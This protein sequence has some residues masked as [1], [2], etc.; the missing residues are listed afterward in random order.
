MAIFVNARIR[1]VD[2]FDLQKC[3]MPPPGA[4][5]FNQKLFLGFV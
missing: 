1:V 5:F 4:D 3:E 2:I